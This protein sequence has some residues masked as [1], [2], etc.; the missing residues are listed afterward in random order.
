MKKLW[1]PIS[2]LLIGSLMIM[3]SPKNKTTASDP[4]RDA[5]ASYW[6]PTPL[7]PNDTSSAG[8]DLPVEQSR[9]AETPADS[10]PS[11]STRP[12]PPRHGSPD[13]AEVDSLKEAKTKQKTR[14]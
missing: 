12:Q 7:S 6:E 9:I 11:V 13:Q 5:P 14:K 3:C 4:E 2:L 1:F 10:L 8:A